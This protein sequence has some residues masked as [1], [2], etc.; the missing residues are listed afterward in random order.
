MIKVL[1]L[2]GSPRGKKS[3]STIIGQ[4]LLQKLREKGMETKS[5]WLIRHFRTEEKLNQ[6]HEAV[7]WADIVILTA[8]LYD[9]CQP[10]IVAK[11][12]ESIA[13][14]G[15]IKTKK[16]FI[17]IINCGF[18]ESSHITAVAISIYRKFA[19]S[20]GFEWAGSL[21]V[22]GGE[23]FR[24]TAGKTLESSGAFGK[25]LLKILGEL[26]DNLSNGGP[27]EDAEFEPPRIFSSKLFMRIGNYFWKSRA[28]KNGARVDARPY[29]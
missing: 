19:Q 8:P 16:R 10:F 9:D 14:R 5:L 12:M 15:K 6:V 29:I 13:G 25:R 18:A 27:Y 21:A 28:K 17:P 26:A 4:P 11:T 23:A 3:A 20:V 1:L 2:V 24:A 22:G 7:D